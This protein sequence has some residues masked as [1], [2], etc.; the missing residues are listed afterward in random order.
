MYTI[1]KFFANSIA[2]T[3]VLLSVLCVL[4]SFTESEHYTSKNSSNI[5]T[6]IAATFK[7]SNNNIE[8]KRNRLKTNFANRNYKTERVPTV[9]AIRRA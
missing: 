9:D 4:L 7:K 8:S 5:F 1:P 2:E 3:Y 6:D